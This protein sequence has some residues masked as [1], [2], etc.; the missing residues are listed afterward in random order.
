MRVV[1]RRLGFVLDVPL[2]DLAHVRVIDQAETEETFQFRL[3]RSP[4]MDHITRR[5]DR[6][7]DFLNLLESCRMLRRQ[8]ERFE[9]DDQRRMVVFGSRCQSCTPL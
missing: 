2:V 6:L 1:K 7:E 4:R 3:R 9:E 8:V 5:T